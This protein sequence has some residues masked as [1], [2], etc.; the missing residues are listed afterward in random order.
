MNAI[1]ES[2]RSALAAAMG[3]GI[4]W[5]LGP[6]CERSKIPV[7]GLRV[8]ERV[9]FN[10]GDTLTLSYRQIVEYGPARTA[11]QFDSILEDSR[12]PA[13]VECIWEGNARVSFVLEEPGG[14]HRFALNTHAGFTRDTAVAG[15]RV[16]LVDVLPRPP[17]HERRLAQDEYRAVVFVR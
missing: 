10:L 6:G 17:G 16:G 11:L 13:D 4:L 5:I 9:Q 12:C 15:L 7:D 2:A 3:F 8:K 1:G 14:R